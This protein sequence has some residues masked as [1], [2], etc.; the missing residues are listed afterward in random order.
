MIRTPFNKPAQK[1]RGNKDTNITSQTILKDKV[2][3]YGRRTS[4]PDLTHF[5]TLY[6][7]NAE[8]SEGHPT[9]TIETH[10]D[11][12]SFRESLNPS[13]KPLEKLV[14]ESN[15]PTVKYLTHQTPK[16]SVKKTPKNSLYKMFQIL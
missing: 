16:N 5:L 1:N 13:S 14:L 8:T 10:S 12:K 6:I 2:S 3:H 7:E 11:A 15:M 9:I 4:F